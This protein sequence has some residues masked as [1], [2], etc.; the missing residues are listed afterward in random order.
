MI[1][2]TGPPGGRAWRRMSLSCCVQ[3]PLGILALVAENELL[4][5]SLMDMCKH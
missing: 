4:Q 2:G 1:G 5:T 3:V